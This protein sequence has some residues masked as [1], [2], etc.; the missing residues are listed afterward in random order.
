MKNFFEVIVLLAI[1]LSLV[2][3]G[4]TMG[5]SVENTRLYNRCLEENKTLAYHE[6]VTICQ[7]RVER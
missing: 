7:K 1:I 3:G 6:T 2:F 5:K 4:V